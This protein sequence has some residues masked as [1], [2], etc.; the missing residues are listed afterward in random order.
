MSFV[1]P[2]YEGSTWK[3]LF[4]EVLSFS[5]CIFLKTEYVHSYDQRYKDLTEKLP[6]WVMPWPKLSCSFLTSVTCIKH[7]KRWNYRSHMF[8]I[9]GRLKDRLIRVSRNTLVTNTCFCFTILGI[10]G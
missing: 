5:I 7:C 4:L 3:S 6:D 1:K 8:P 2:L 9:K 10:D